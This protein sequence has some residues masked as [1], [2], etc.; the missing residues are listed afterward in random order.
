MIIRLFFLLW[1]IL[2]CNVNAVNQLT[3]ILTHIIDSYIIGILPGGNSLKSFVYYISLEKSDGT[4][5]HV[6]VGLV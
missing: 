6:F 4:F 5:C 1:F 2:L 3:H